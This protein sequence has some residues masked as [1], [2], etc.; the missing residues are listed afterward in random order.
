MTTGSEPALVDTN[1]LAYA[2]YPSSPQHPAS[3][4]LLETAG[5][6]DAG[7][8]VA[9]QNLLEFLAVVT[10][11][12]RVSPP[13]TVDEALDAISDLL[14]LPGLS[15]LPVPIDAVARWMDLVRRHQVSGM[16]VFDVQ[17]VAVMQGNQVARIYTFNVADF[18]PFGGLRVLTP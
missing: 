18:R 15:L 3:R 9:P 2:F 8:W 17:P 13:R 7:P 12:R 14:A 4:A 16:K 1:V 10:N 11:P 6:P 5:Q